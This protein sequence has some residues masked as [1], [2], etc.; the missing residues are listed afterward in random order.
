[1][2]TAHNNDR[3]QLYFTQPIYDTDQSNKR[4]KKFKLQQKAEP[5]ININFVISNIDERY[6]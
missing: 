4:N 2:N 1:M 5:L 6:L 3:A